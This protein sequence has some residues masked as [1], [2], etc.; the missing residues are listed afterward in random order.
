MISSTSRKLFHDNS[1][2]IVRYRKIISKTPLKH[3][4]RLEMIRKSTSALGSSK[5]KYHSK[6]NITSESIIEVPAVLFQYSQ[7]I[8]SAKC[9]DLGIVVAPEQEQRF[10]TVFIQNAEMRRLNLS[11]QK[12]AIE[13]SLTLSRILLKSTHFAYIDLSKNKLGNIGIQTLLR[14]LH[15]NSEIVHLD[16]SSNDISP[17]N[18]SEILMLLARHPSLYSLD[19][20]SHQFLYRNKIGPNE[21]LYALLQSKTLSFLNLSGTNIRSEGL[22]YI[23]LGIE[24]NKTL[25]SLNLS[26]NGIK[27]NVIKELVQVLVTTKINEI[28]LE[29]NLLDEIAA[30]EIAFFF[31]GYY[32]YGTISRINLA[33]NIIPT[34]GIVKIFE[35]LVKENYL[36]QLNL[37]KNNFSGFL[38]VIERFV[39]GNKRLKFLN[40]SECSLRIESFAKLCEGLAEN[41]VMD[42]LNL[43]GNSCKDLGAAS[44]AR[45]LKKNIALKKLIL[46]NNGIKT[47]GGVAIVAALRTNKVL[48]NLDLSNNEL[49]DDVGEAFFNIF[50]SNYS[51][52][53][54][55][56][57]L[58]PMSA[59]YPNDINRYLNRNREIDSKQEFS[60][61]TQRKSLL[62][63]AQANAETVK[64]KITEGK[65]EKDYIQNKINGYKKK[66]QKIK[67]EE[68]EKLEEMKQEFKTLK[69]KNTELSK[70]MHDLQIETRVRG[71]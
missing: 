18:I 2:S 55:K 27:G 37:A 41:T 31:T 28:N 46:S 68:E 21:A 38:D 35:A 62:N 44:M 49:K 22:K 66:I 47:E 11:D 19:L 4:T 23:I 24:N 36:E 20:S 17:T 61:I 39:S 7:E 16:L 52:T 64:T 59:K 53:N 54:L 40:L 1:E 25:V 29:N 56:I 33:K 9:K 42:S 8:Y 63:V 60:K 10:S 26:S 30:E 70:T 32:G 34:A 3:Q 14:S 65:L 45:A 57:Q 67:K 5:L 50:A 15:L 58:N 13:S 69:E 71:I 48:K 43:S 51:L 12:L 6:F